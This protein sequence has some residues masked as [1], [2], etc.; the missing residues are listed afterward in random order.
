MTPWA[1]A[2]ASALTTYFNEVVPSDQSVERDLS[3]GTRGRLFGSHSFSQEANRSNR[4]IFFCD[5]DLMGGVPN[6]IR[7]P[8]E[9]RRSDFFAKRKRVESLL[10]PEGV[11][12]ETH[13]NVSIEP[14]V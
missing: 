14:M 1:V 2:A 9:A 13:H 10:A 6:A 5:H 11:C 12:R 4:H 8:S 3:T 7:G